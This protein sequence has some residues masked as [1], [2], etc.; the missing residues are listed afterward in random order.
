[1]GVNL[2][3]SAPWNTYP[4]NAQPLCNEMQLIPC[5]VPIDSVLR[6]TIRC[7]CRESL[8]ET[9]CGWLLDGATSVECEFGF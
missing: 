3:I 6:F 9:D 2:S 7:P 5:P 8:G 4:F 1:M